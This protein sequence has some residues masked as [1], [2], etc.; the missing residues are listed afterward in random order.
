[1][2]LWCMPWRLYEI[3]TRV[4]RF[5]GLMYRI[6]ANRCVDVPRH[7]SAGLGGAFRIAV[8]GSIG[9]QTF[10]TTLVPRGG[11]RHR[12]FLSGRAWRALGLCEG[13][14]VSVRLELDREAEALIRREV[15]AGAWAQQPV[16]TA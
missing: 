2:P 15:P 12:L 3:E 8:R 4:L 10:R 11:G 14:P 9:G 16:P 1:M 7:V 13:D 5:R 6:G